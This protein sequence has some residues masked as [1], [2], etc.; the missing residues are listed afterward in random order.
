METLITYYN[1]IMISGVLKK[2]CD[3]RELMIIQ[4]CCLIL[5]IYKNTLV[6]QSIAYKTVHYRQGI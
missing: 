5:I 3:G 2:N 4:I 6:G 1:T